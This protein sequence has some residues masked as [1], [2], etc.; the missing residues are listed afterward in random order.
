[1]IIEDTKIKERT[2]E[3]LNLRKKALMEIT[4]V[5]NNN[6]ILFFIWGGALLGMIRDKDFIKWDWDVEI[7]F[8]AKDLKEN[9]DTI[10]EHLKKDN[11]NIDYDNKIELKINI[12][13][14]TSKEI[15]SFSLSGWRYDYFTNNYIRNKLNVPKKFFHKMEKFKCFNCEFFC[16]GPVEEYLK[17]TYGDWLTPLKTSDKN[18]Y[19]SNQNLRENN[20]KIYSK[21]NKLINF[22]IR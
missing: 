8:F 22:F 9:W 4:N 15:T 10:I 17:Y 6:N 5:L 12:S 3:Q 19:L 13:K 11:F 21:I 1:M 14:Y 18:K 7:G 2:I 16:P 20:W